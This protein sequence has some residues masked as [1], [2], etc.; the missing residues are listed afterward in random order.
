MSKIP[1]DLIRVA[2]VVGESDEGLTLFIPKDMT[3]TFH[4]EDG[5]RFLTVLFVRQQGSGVV[6]WLPWGESDA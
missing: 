2:K 3:G 1:S 4:I 6:P 5:D